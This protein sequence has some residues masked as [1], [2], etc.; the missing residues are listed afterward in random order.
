MEL[1]AVSA[2]EE[3]MDLTIREED[4]SDEIQAS[5][6]PSPRKSRESS[7]TAWILPG[8]LWAEAEM[9]IEYGLSDKAVR[10]V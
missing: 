8:V 6:N 2:S 10:L 1:K 4:I 3:D 9:C 7:K 5:P